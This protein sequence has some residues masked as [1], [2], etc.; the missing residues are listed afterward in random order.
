M[1][2]IFSKIA[3]KNYTLACALL[4]LLFIVLTGMSIFLGFRVF[5]GHFGRSQVEELI[6]MAF[7][8]AGLF[9]GGRTHAAINY[10]HSHCYEDAKEEAYE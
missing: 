10:A 1:E 5:A 7:L 3:K 9:F 8:F 2:R 4:A 6:G